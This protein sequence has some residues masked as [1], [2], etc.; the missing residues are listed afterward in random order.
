LNPAG[1]LALNLVLT[2]VLVG[3]ASLAAIAVAV[4][5]Q[6]ASLYAGRRLGLA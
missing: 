1:A 4:A 2:P 5:V 3:A 6:G